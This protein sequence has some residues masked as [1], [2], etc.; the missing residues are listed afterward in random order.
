VVLIT[1]SAKTKANQSEKV[2]VTTMG[3]LFVDKLRQ[4][5]HLF[6]GVDVA[7]FFSMGE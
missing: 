2:L 4:K 1:K 7:V 5:C 3:E 6:I